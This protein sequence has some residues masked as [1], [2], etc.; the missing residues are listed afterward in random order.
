MCVEIANCPF[1][2]HSRGSFFR[3]FTFFQH[4]HAPDAAHTLLLLLTVRVEFMDL[5]LL[6]A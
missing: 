3:V 5:Q 2:L 4:H 6:L 1:M